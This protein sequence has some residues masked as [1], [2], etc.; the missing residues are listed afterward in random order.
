VPG[1]VATLKEQFEQLFPG[2]WLLKGQNQKN[3]QTGLQEIDLGPSR[4]LAR[5]RVT[6]WIGTASSGKTTLLRAIVA[7]WCT[8]GLHIV[9][10]D[11]ANKLIPADWAFVDQGNAGRMPLNMVRTQQNRRALAFEIESGQGARQWDTSRIVP[12]HASGKFWVV[13]NLS[14]NG[15]GPKQ[16]ALWATEQLIRSNLFDVV[17]FD[18]TD[19]PPLSSRFYARLQR[20]LDTAKAALLVVKDVKDCPS[21]SA[22]GA[23]WGAHTRL[24]FQ[25]SAPLIC[26]PGLNGIAAITPAIRG[27]VWKDGL[28]NNL[29]VVIGSYATNR[30]FTHP[31]V[32]DRRT[33][34]TRA[35]LKK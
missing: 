33:P 1:N 25:W 21:M 32:P 22:N 35:V 28:T 34:K 20:S 15:Q 12:L 8:Y 2:K 26:E 19:S 30:L 3:L 18:A 23:S 29:E 24:Q 14:S 9:Y 7:N 11:A 27:S 10:V 17:V 31:Q 6:E 16:S 5:K 13:R 4:G